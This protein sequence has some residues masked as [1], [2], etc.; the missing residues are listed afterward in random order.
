IVR[1][2][3]LSKF[4]KES[5]FDNYVLLGKGEEGMKGRNRASLLADLFE[6]FLGA[7]YLDQG[8]K[9]VE[10]F[11]SLVIFPKI[12]AGAFSH[13]MDY[14][15]ELQEYLQRSGEVTIHYE[16]VSETGPAHQ[17]E[18]TVEV[19]VEDHFLGKGTGSSKKMAEQHAAENA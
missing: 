18:F 10:T 16:L 7:L 8:M 9:S 15:T 2:T 19:K 5:K 17:K 4:A 12:K 14:K 3:S 1:E 13:G 6:A 11:L